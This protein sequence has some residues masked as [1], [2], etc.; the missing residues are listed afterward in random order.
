MKASLSAAKEG[1]RCAIGQVSSETSTSVSRRVALLLLFSLVVLS[2]ANSRGQE[3]TYAWSIDNLSDWEN[4]SSEEVQ[5][6]LRSASEIGGSFDLMGNGALLLEK[7]S[8]DRPFSQ[9]EFFE[10][11]GRWTSSWH[12]A[13]ADMSLAQVEADIIT[14]GQKLEMTGWTKFSGNPLVAEE[15]FRHNTD[16]TLVLQTPGGR[17]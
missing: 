14:Y 2:P 6:A 16:Q 1:V 15:D 17:P 4:A 10:T 9:V 11:R 8:A 7:T 3:N 12:E 13:P 5:V